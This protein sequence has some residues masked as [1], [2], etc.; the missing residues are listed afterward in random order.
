MTI[1]PLRRMRLCF[2]LAGC[3]AMAAGTS[4]AGGAEDLSLKQAVTMA[5]AF[6]QDLKIVRDQVRSSELTRDQDRADYL[7]SLTAGAGMNYGRNTRTSPSDATYESLSTSLSASLNLFKGF[8][9]RAS[10]RKAEYAL[11]SDKD[12]WSRTRQTVIFNTVSAYLETL[13]S[14]ERIRVAVQN[15]ADNRKQLEWIEA[16]CS[17][18]RRPLTDLYQQQAQTAGA[19]LDLLT[20]R[21]AY[22][23]NTMQLKEIIGIPVLAPV[24]VT[25]GLDDLGIGDVLAEPDTM[26]REALETRSDLFALKNTIWAREMA[27]TEASAGYYP[28]VDLVTELGSSWSS[29]DEADASDQWGDD[30]LNARVGVTVSLP[31]FDRWL[32]R[33]RVGQAR[34]SSRTARH[35]YIKLQRRIEVEIGQAFFEYQAALSKV[36][37]TAFQMTYAAKAL[38]STRQRY[39]SGAATLTELAGAQ[40]TYVEAQY[41]QVEAGLNRVIQAM[42]LSFSRGDLDEIFETGDQTP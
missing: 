25:D 38:E 7:P 5:L 41:N 27:V 24:N 12:T 23:V 34:I 28:T 13:T 10:L 17:V 35:E 39:E 32:T 9:D 11:F 33:N 29:L 37:V 18:G 30:N 8:E 42:S 21:Q 3:L 26:I 22:R 15:L 36:E 16:F 31:L 1:T 2:V 14:K 40:A 6:N 20:T 19:R 4:Q